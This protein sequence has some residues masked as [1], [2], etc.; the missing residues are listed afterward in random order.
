MNASH[1]KVCYYG[2]RGRREKTG[3]ER[4]I[5]VSQSLIAFDTDHIKG[6]VFG[7]NK[8]KE[9]R[10]ASSILDSLNRALTTQEASKRN[11]TKI[12]ANGGSALFIV[13][14]VEAEA[15]GKEVQK[16]YRKQTGDGASITYAV[17]PL[18][19]YDSEK[20]NIMTIMKFDD[21]V[22]MQDV[23][24]LL[25]MRLR[26]AKDSPHYVDVS[27]AQPSHALLCT[28]VSC[29]VNYVQDV[30]K[31]PYDAEEEAGLYCRICIA[32]HAEDKEVKEK[33][34]G[35]IRAIQN[36]SIEA[37]TL[38]ARI[39]RSLRKYDYDL[40]SIPDRPKDFNV[41]RSFTH[42]K[43]YLGL[44]YADANS[45]GR[46]LEKL[47]T[48]QKVEEFA[49]MVDGAVFDAMAIAI[50]T[51]LP[52][53]KGLFPFDILMVGGDDIAMVV[54]ADKA[55]QV[56]HTL[57]EKFHELTKEYT[58]SVG[59]VLAPVT[60][61]FSLQ[62]ELVEATLKAAKK[63]GVQQQGGSSDEKLEESR[64]NFV[65]VTGNT[66]LG[67][68]KEYDEM[69]RKADG[70]TREFYATMRPYTLSQMEWLLDRLRVGNSKRL[71]RTKLH[72]LRQ[73]ILKR[74]HTTSIVE[75]LA[76]FRNWKPDERDFMKKMAEKFDTRSPA[77]QRDMGILFPWSLD[78]KGSS[79]SLT[80]YRTP[81]LDFIDLY[82][83][84]TS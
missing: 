19:A 73:A 50:K 28:C 57:A 52:V 4:G 65:V 71:G 43:E 34:P 5:T 56:A 45:M 18:P 31:D 74:N 41:F 60:Y 21:G 66:S 81:L 79:E 84:V 33:L 20:E 27:V 39:L 11:A 76:L 42:G 61:P 15:L 29:G 47:P 12:F 54:P 69:H 14:S 3:V 1:Q 40:T 16:Q 6:Y 80:V 77:Q 53:Q 36:H 55:M 62:R 9:I 35:L 64:V 37:N 2:E 51:Y 68:Q 49:D 38:W 17:Q 26:L 46:A 63:S 10:G 67:Y 70:S 59:V 7:T 48:L 75:S 72:Q 8:L 25:R 24:K 13:D 44:I 30:W 58:L 22:T 78:G 82:D 83:F 32:K 23:L